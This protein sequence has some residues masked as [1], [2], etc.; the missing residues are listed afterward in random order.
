MKDDDVVDFNDLPDD[1]F[2]QDN[3]EIPASA[4]Q[5]NETSA[6]IAKQL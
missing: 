3:K 2:S 1:L 5:P 4:S 6:P